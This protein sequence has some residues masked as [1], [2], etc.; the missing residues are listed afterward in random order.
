VSEYERGPSQGPRNMFQ[1]VAKSLQLRGFR[2]GTFTG[3]TAEMRTVLGALL[4]EGRLALREHVLDG[5]ERAPEALVTLLSGGNTGKV[6]VRL[7]A[8]RDRA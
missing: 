6:L 3:R 4:A 1:V 5:L 8:G 2:A 7:S